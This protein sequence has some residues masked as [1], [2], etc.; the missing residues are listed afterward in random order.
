MKLKKFIKKRVSHPDK[1]KGKTEKF[2]VI[3][4]VY[5]SKKKGRKDIFI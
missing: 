4:T 2:E 1:I 5:E 3:Q